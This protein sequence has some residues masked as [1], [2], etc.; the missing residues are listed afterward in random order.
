MSW[1]HF[2]DAIACLQGNTKLELPNALSTPHFFETLRR[3]DELV[4]RPNTQSVLTL[5][6]RS[7]TSLCEIPKDRIYAM[8]N[9]P[10]PTFHP[11]TTRI[12][13]DYSKSG[14]ETYRQFAL[15]RIR[16]H[17]LD[18]LE[19]AYVPIDQPRD[20]NWPSWVPDWSHSPVYKRALSGHAGGRIQS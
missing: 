11:N 15:E 4:T 1:W 7:R 16:F 14:L 5:L 18:L 6:Q 12:R 13:P 19:Y 20:Q 8:M 9:I 17:S 10:S 3:I 2:R